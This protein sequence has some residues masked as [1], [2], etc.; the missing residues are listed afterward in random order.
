[1]NCNLRLTDRWWRGL[2]SETLPRLGTITGEVPNLH[3]VEA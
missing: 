1:V 3:I 2:G